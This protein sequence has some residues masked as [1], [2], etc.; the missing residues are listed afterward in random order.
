[1]HELPIKEPYFRITMVEVQGG[2][3]YNELI[4]KLKDKAQLMG[5][6]GVIITEKDIDYLAGIGIKYNKNI[7]KIFDTLNVIKK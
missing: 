4:L 6:D 5:I 2:N 7:N 1:M 3:S